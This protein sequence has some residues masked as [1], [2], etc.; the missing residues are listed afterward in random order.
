MR[1]ERED[2]G[3]LLR[4]D[5]AEARSGRSAFV[6]CGEI[7]YAKRQARHLT[8]RVDGREDRREQIRN[9]VRGRLRVRSGGGHGAFV[10]VDGLTQ[11]VNGVHAAFVG[12]DGEQEGQGDD[13]SGAETPEDRR[14]SCRACQERKPTDA[15]RNRRRRH[16]E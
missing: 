2:Y 6:F 3:M 10:L 5:C 7:E 14:E 8:D 9:I 1:R 15:G 12:E 11:V 13:G 16:L 4:E